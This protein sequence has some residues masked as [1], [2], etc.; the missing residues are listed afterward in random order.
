[1]TTLEHTSVDTKQNAGADADKTRYA[2]KI[3]PSGTA[4][5][6]AA[7]TL[8]TGQVIKERYV[9]EDKIGSGGMSDIYRAT[10]L[11]LQQA[12]VSECTVAIKV[13]QPQFVNQPEALQLLL[14]EAHKT[15]QLSHPN[16]VRVFDV[17]RDQQHYFI[18]ME[19]LDGESLEQVIKRYKPKGLP[20]KSAIKLL[21]QIADALRFA[22]QI[23]IVHA[24]LKPANIMVNRSGIVKVLD[25][26]VSQQ[27]QL[28]HD[29][30]AAEQHN[31]STPLSGYTPAYASP[32]LLAGKTPSV[33]D[34]VFSFAC[35]CY[36]LLSSK[37]PYE[38]LPADQ[39]LQ[40]Q[41]RAL[42]PAHVN[43]LQWQALKKA[44]QFLPEQ[45]NISLAQLMHRLQ[46]NL[47]LP[48]GISAAVLALAFGVSQYHGGQ[49]QQL[50][51]LSDKASQAEQQ[52]QL[53]QQLSAASAAQLLQQ[54]DNPDTPTWLRQALLRN[55]QTAVLSHFEQQI[56]TLISD[57]SFSYPNYPQIEQLLAQASTLYPDS[58][59]LAQIGSSI[60]RSKQTAIDVLR[61]QMR[62]LLLE[63]QYQRQ[64]QGSDPY[65]ILAELNRID[66]SYTVRP[67]DAEAE[68]YINAY[69]Q[70]VAENDAAALQRLIAIGKQ[71][72][73]GH[74][75]TQTLVKQGMVL[76][77]AVDD[78]AAYRLAV[79]QGSNVQFPYQAA[80]LFY[81]H[82]FNL[83][84]QQLAA[85]S[86]AIEVDLVYDKLQQFNNLVPANFSL[87]VAIR[88]QL[89]DKYLS[90]S[91]E[92][93]QSNQV[94]TA[95][96]L[97]RRANEL[98][99]SI[100]S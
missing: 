85:S 92:L 21:K 73:T 8:Q 35:L 95:E 63:Q 43:L 100:N 48:A 28:N 84:Q 76:A 61:S 38:R 54:L 10:D 53:F 58:H 86:K 14:Q 70:A 68:A 78:M 69:Q 40:Q 75:D 64:A 94:R 89:A 19:F 29:I 16:I 6:T 83:L 9:L 46:F 49:Q 18:V 66:S 79:E 27:L 22:H 88:R 26:G 65:K 57:R 99:S 97:M 7:S 81:Q 44:L 20:L 12:G 1:M 71:L 74:S 41:K 36:E 93:L 82:S 17:D 11:F 25:F 59:I 47:W 42:K 3:S 67:E 96:R 72:F 91:A 24:D 30:Y 56:D 77:Q 15:Q 62:Q 5:S 2:V 31:H 37:H 80:E 33:S 13:L 23:G 60:S 52:Q 45:R 55:Q 32:Q 50:A 51:L 98:M 39:A 90:M 34:D 4:A 87:H